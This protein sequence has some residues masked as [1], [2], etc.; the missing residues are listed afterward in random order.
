MGR[1]IQLH[2]GQ[3]VLWDLA[4]KEIEK[5]TTTITVCMVYYRLVKS[6]LRYGDVV[7]GSLSKTKLAALQRLQTRVLK[8]IKN[9]KTKDT[10]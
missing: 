7:W 9:A 6:Q 3:N 10:W 8:I 5:Y 2:N 1:S 4:I